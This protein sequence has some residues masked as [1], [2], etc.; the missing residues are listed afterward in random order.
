[1]HQEFS[2]NSNSLN[3]A[4]LTSPCARIVV[5]ISNRFCVGGRVRKEIKNREGFLM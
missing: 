3:L 1:M 2:S 4:R 5:A